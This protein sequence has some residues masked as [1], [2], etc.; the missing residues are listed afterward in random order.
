M[1]FGSGEQKGTYWRYR[2]RIELAM[3]ELNVLVEDWFQKMR[4]DRA[5]V[6]AAG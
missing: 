4:V 2:Y 5:L 1:N 3:L 6:D